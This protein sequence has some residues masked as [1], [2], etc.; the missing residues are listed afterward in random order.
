MQEFRKRYSGRTGTLPGLPAWESE[1]LFTRGIDTPEKAEAFL[2]PDLKDLHDPFRMRDMDRAVALIRDAIRENVRI[3]VYGDYDV[4]GVSAVTVLLETLR[5]EGADA[6]F[7]VPLR[8][9]EGYGLNEKAVRETAERGYGMLITVD[10]GITGVEEVRLAKELGLK[11]I[12][13]DHHEV[14]ETLPAA[15]AVLNPLLGDYPFRRLCGAGVA[16]KICQALQGMAGVEKRLEIAALATVADVVP[17]TGENRVIVREGMRRMAETDRPGLRAMT[18]NAKI[19]FP[20]RSDDIAFRLGP[21]LNAAGRLEDAAQGVR[22]LMTRDPAE[23]REIADHLEENN[24][25]RQQMQQEIQEQALEEMASSGKVDLRRDRAIVLDGEGWDAGLIGLVAGKLCEKFHHPT[26]I[27]SRQGEKAVGSCRSVEGVNIWR[28]LNL[29]EQEG[30]LFER[31]GGHEQAAGLTLPVS[32]IDRFRE[33]LNRVIRENCDDRSFLPV[34]EYDSEMALDQ[35]TLETIDAL[36]ALEPTGCGNPAPVFLCR[37]VSAQEVRPVGKDG[38]HLKLTL[39][40]GRTSRGGIGFGLGG[41]ADR[42]LARVDV[43]FRPTRN[44]FNGRVAPQLQVQAIRASRDGETGNPEDPDA[45]FLACLQEMGPS[46]AKKA[47]HT[48]QPAE[49][50]PE[51]LLKERLEKVDASR[52][53]LVGVYLALKDFRGGSL[54]ELTRT[55]GISREQALFALTAFAQLGLLRWEREPFRVEMLPAARKLDLEESPVVSC[56]RRLGAGAEEA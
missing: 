55:A 1:L 16:L 21:R 52:D 31:F 5:E 56:L 8:H 44:E 32:E 53:A 26:V 3:L 25:K 7:R 41:A 34:A 45:F 2:H 30:P 43:L 22:L 47:D 54:E 10:C 13:T 24:R 39:V 29:C 40:D 11:V 27:L 36:E 20:M 15:D 46:P 33:R 50:R 6:D 49:L 12:V 42:T 18:E 14:P 28:M 38:S 48:P 37:D 51:H 4:D 17:L 35:V 9:S 19:T 23:A